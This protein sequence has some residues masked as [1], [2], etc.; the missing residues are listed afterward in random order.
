MKTTSILLIISAHL[1]LV[2][3]PVS[4]AP[5]HNEPDG[6]PAIQANTD[7]GLSGGR[8]YDVTGDNWPDL[9]TR[10][11][12]SGVLQV[13]PHS[14][15]VNGTST[16]LPGVQVGTGWQVHNWIGVGNFTDSVAKDGTEQDEREVYLGDLIARRASDGAL[17]LYQHSGTFNGTS[18]WLPPVVV[19]TG[20]GTVRRIWVADADLDG[21]D[22]L[23]AMDSQFTVWVYPN[24]RFL[25]G[26]ST[27]T[28][29]IK[30]SASVGGPSSDVR[31]YH[32][33]AP[34]YQDAPDFISALPGS[35]G[36]VYYMPN[37]HGPVNESTWARWNGAGARVVSYD[38]V[39]SS[40]TVTLADVTGNG[41]EDLV[42]SLYNGELWL[43]PVRVPRLG[44]AAGVDA[45][46]FLGGGWDVYDVI[47]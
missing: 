40:A 6:G 3:A 22:D 2:V 41:S 28:A 7:A 17:L 42:T 9:V 8:A 35:G 21:F 11:R 30:V 36:S 15:L 32:F 46:V 4:A 39:V 45:R 43:H 23:I 26:A 12:A 5:S 29:R 38:A 27:F 16:F 10:N 13:H 18:T 24:S 19:A 44:Q 20:W 31:A 47:T 37:S 1:A 14:G 34:W 25:N 33:F